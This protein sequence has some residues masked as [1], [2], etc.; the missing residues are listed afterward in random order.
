[1]INILVVAHG[2]M[3]EGM[4]SSI[5]M[6]MGEPEHVNFV[7]F[8]EDIGQEELKELLDEKV[9]KISKDNQYLFMVDIKGGTPFNVASS[10]SFKNDNV[11]V[12]YGVNLPILVETII[13]SQDKSLAEFAQYLTEISGTTLGISEL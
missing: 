10:Y 9:V 3:A 4:K 12:F 11:A 1:M 2:Q 13:S 5:M 6:L 7:N 8:A